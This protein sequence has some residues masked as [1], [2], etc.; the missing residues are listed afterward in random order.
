[1]RRE[2]SAGSIRDERL[3][4]RAR[5]CYVARQFVSRFP[6]CGTSGEA[7]GTFTGSRSSAG[8]GRN[9]WFRLSAI[10]PNA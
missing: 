2:L 1:M 3:G 7:D 6:V 4:V 9:G 10:A 8:V 5:H